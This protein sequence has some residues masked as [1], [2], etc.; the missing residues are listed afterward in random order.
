MSL[1]KSTFNAYGN[2]SFHWTAALPTPGAN[3]PPGQLPI[4]LAAPQN[5]TVNEGES[6]TFQV[7]ATGTPPV[8][9]QWRF[10]GAPLTGATSPTLMLTNVNLDH[11][12]A[13]DVAVFGPSGSTVSAP[14]TLFVIKQP[15]I[16]LPPLNQAV[17]PTSNA[18][19]RVVATGN[20]TLRYQWRFNGVALADAT[21]N[22]F[23]VTSAGLEHRG[24]YTVL[25]SDEIGSIVTVPATLKLLI[26]PLI[27][28]QPLGQTVLPGGTVTLSIVVTN[29]ATLPVS[30]RWRR[31]GATYANYFVDSHTNF[32]VITNV[33]V[34]GTNWTVV[35]TNAATRNAGF[36]SSNAF[37]TILT[38]TNANSLP[39]E[40]ET[41]YGFGPGNPALRDADVD[42]D[43]ATNVEEFLAGTD[44]TNAASVLRVVIPSTTGGVQIS[45]GAISNRTYSV[46]YRDTPGGGLWNKLGDVPAR[47]INRVETFLDPDWTTNRFYRAVVPWQP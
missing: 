21:N 15:V 30:Y 39:D 18:T 41:S 43:G 19:F 44:P 8:L 6:A 16:I 13:Y 7:S 9:Y 24:S 14:A 26:D 4:I 29:T 33:Q 42:G 5:V 32:V 35:V 1:Q 25:I 40:W 47:A 20:G 23:T 22:T 27:V 38:D 36:L 31:G 10:R 46:L 12:G 45:F 11:A 17:R 3:L 28:Q 37:L 2:D 34:T